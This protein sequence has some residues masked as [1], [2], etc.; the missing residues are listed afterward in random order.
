[1]A[2]ALC[3]G[4]IN[5]AAA[6]PGSPASS[7]SSHQIGAG[8]VASADLTQVEEELSQVFEVFLHADPVTGVWSLGDVEAAVAAGVD[9][10]VLSQI[11]ADFNSAGE[12]PAFRKIGDTKWAK[13]VIGWSVG[14]GVIGLVD[15]T[16][17]G[18]LKRGKYAQVA[19]WLVRVA[20]RLALRGGVVGIVAGLA[21]GVAAC[22]ISH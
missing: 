19:S 17:A 7:V 1:M 20:P 18:W 3:V 5:P 8:T 2:L 10:A 12:A 15:G 14:T 9:V 16:V 11:V 21:A 4:S 22:S 6:D 13:C